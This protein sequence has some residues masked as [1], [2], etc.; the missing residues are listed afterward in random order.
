[1]RD[2]SILTGFILSVFALIGSQLYMGILKRKC[3][4]DSPNNNMTALEFFQFTNNSNNW[5]LD[6]ANNYI[7]CGNSS[8]AGFVAT[9]S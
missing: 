6:S 8:G 3:V 7:L 5:A 1:L 2:V 9:F 4:W